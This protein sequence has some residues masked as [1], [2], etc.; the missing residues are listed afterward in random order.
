MDARMDF[1]SSLTCIPT[2]C[3][4]APL[5]NRTTPSAFSSVSQLSSRWCRTR[6][7]DFSQERSTLLISRPSSSL[8][9]GSRT[10]LHQKPEGVSSLMKAASSFTRV[11]LSPTAD[12]SAW[13]K[14][15]K[16]GTNV[17]H[18]VFPRLVLHR[19]LTSIYMGVVKGEKLN[20]LRPLDSEILQQRDAT[21]FW[22]M[23]PLPLR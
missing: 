4:L 1:S 15:L 18:G 17:S 3:P 6:V 8:Q 9:G 5:I 19:F 12:W 22:R 14:R 11:T 23:P 2:P 20:H 13:S 10:L 21:T 16:R 7:F